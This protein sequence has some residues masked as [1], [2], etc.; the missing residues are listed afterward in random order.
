MYMNETCIF[1]VLYSSFLV[2]FSPSGVL[3]DIITNLCT[4]SSNKPIVCQTAFGKQILV[5][6]LQY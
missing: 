6:N 1:F 3:Y 5:K 4:Y 2:L